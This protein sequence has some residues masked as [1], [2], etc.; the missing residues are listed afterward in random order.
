MRLRMIIAAP[1]LLIGLA[2]TGLLTLTMA[3][4]M[5]LR[6]DEEDQD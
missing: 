3:V 6:G 5:A 2:L 4:P 1:F